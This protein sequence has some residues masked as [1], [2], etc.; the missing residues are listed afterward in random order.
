MKNTQLQKFQHLW[1]FRQHFG[2]HKRKSDFSG[3]KIIPVFSEECPYPVWHKDE[4]MENANPES[5]IYDKNKDFW[6]QVW[7]VFKNSPIAHN[8]GV[9]NENSEYNDDCWYS[10]NCYLCHS[11]LKCE[12]S[13]YLF[14]TVNHKDCQFCV[15]SFDLHKCL[16]V[17]Y[18]FDCY[19]VKYWIDIKRCKN[20]SFLFDCEDCEDC[21]LSWNLKNKRYCIANKQYSK[22]DYEKEIKKYNLSSRKVYNKL[23]EQFSN[24]IEKSAYWKEKH[25]TNVEKSSWDYL[26][27]C[28]NCEKCFYIEDSENCKNGIRS[29]WVKSS[30]NFVSILHSE[31]VFNSV[32]AQDN[33]YNINYC[34]NVIQSKNLEYCSNCYKCE[35]CFLSSW[36]VWKNFYILNK[37]Y[38]EDEYNKLKLE[39]I[40]DMKNLWIYWEFFPKYFSPTTYEESWA[41]SH[42]FLT[43][44]E[45]KDLW[46]RISDLKEDKIDN[47]KDISELPDIL[48]NENIEEVKWWYYDKNSKKPFAITDT[49]ISFYKKTNSAIN[50][51]Y[52]ITRLKQNFAWMFPTVELRKTKCSISGKDIETTLPKKLDSRI[53]SLEDYNKMFY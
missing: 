1:A 48:T 19:N 37:K 41:N 16:D 38:Q 35:N 43:L 14:R 4:W 13:S 34:F 18:G 32:L 36:L 49:D 22:E 20:S 47:L 27:N 15:F 53:I 50:D 51:K 25:F 26:E 52:Y 28:N 29:L 24:F 17:I 11:L 42:C 40:E 2:I 30:E 9:W 44:E 7:E 23:I 21:L 46:F 3:K 31:K 5:A 10:K 12:D 33:C 8:V 45:Q 39:I 6:G